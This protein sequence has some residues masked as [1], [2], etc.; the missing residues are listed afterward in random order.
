MS[1]YIKIKLNIGDRLYP[2]TIERS[3]E[4]FFR[5][6]VKKIESSLKKLEEN[7]SVRDKQDLLAMTCIQYAAKLQQNLSNNNKIDEEID[8]K[9]T[10]MINLIDNKI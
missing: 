4:I 1:D 2:L 6:A 10:N 5:D 9:I 3:Q 7:Y 8:E